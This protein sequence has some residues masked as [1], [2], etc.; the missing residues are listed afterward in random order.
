MDSFVLPV[1][2]APTITT[3]PE[4]E[5]AEQDSGPLLLRRRARCRRW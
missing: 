5:G 2:V 4:D 3:M 1:P